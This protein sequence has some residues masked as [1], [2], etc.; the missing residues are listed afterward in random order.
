MKDTIQKALQA[1]ADPILYLTERSDLPFSA[2]I[3]IRQQIGKDLGDRM[4][5]A[6]QEALNLYNKVIIIGTDSPTFP[7]SAFQEAFLRLEDHDVVLGPSE[8]GGY[9]LIA[10]NKLI[11]EIFENIPWSTDK[12]LPVTLER[13]AKR[14]VSLLERCFDVDHPADLER[15][16]NELQD[17]PYLSN[18]RAWIKTFFDR[19]RP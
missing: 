3:Q 18:T 2:G 5:H 10:L 11:P 1:D 16:K 12:V 15:L 9:Y 6:F 7:V 4:L 13:L 19:K 17:L 8:D 14:K